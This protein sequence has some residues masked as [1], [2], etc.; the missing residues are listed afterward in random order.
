M[1]KHSLGRTCL[2][3]GLFLAVAGC[4]DDGD[5]VEEGARQVATTIAGGLEKATRLSATLTGAA[6]VPGPGDP[7][8]TG[9]AVVNLDVS[10]RKVCYEVNVQ[11]IDRP[12]GMHI[13]EGDA[14]KSG[15]IVVS[16]STPTASDTT[17]EGCREVEAALLARLGA[18][19][20]GFYVNVHSAAHQQG[21]IRGQLS[22]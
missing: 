21:A 22:Q 15:D 11:K 13:H 10:E 6:E 17:T 16:L 5:D 4:G 9:T 8:G 19:P 7:D 12:V 1:S 3:A 2:V 20:G 18:N 14:G